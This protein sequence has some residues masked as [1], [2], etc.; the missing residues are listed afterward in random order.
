MNYISKKFLLTYSWCQSTIRGFPGGSEGKGS[1]CGRPR[2]NPRV[3][4]IPWRRQWHPT[5]VLL[6]GKS[7]G[8]RSLVGYS[9]WGG[10]GSDMTERLHFHFSSLIYNTVL[11][12]SIQ[13]SESV[14]YM[15]MC[16]YTC[17]HTDVLF[18]ILSPYKLLHWKWFL[19]LYSRV[20]NKEFF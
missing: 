5:P 17:T 10:K 8:W 19:V 16:M 6:P 11:V 1:A 18:Q 2:F 20:F 12:S 9:P 14:L 4:K 7:H 3:G 13:Q 15:H